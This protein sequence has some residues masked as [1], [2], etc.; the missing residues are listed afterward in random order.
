MLLDGILHLQ[1][2][3]LE[4]LSLLLLYCMKF[5]KTENVIHE[6][7]SST[8]FLSDNNSVNL[9]ESKNFKIKSPYYVSK[10]NINL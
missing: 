1:E 8:I 5:I 10:K 6:S 9:K 2:Q 7:K 3:A 4:F